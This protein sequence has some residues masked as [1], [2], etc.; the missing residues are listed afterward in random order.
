M[1]SL[2][3]IFWDPAFL[4]Q[5]EIKNSCQKKKKLKLGSKRRTGVI[6]IPLWSSFPPKENPMRKISRTNLLKDK[7]FKRK[8]YWRKQSTLLYY[9][10][11]I[12]SKKIKLEG[13]QKTGSSLTISIGL[14]TA[15]YSQVLSHYCLTRELLPAVFPPWAGSLLFNQPGELRLLCVPHIDAKLSADTR[16]T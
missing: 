15:A 14:W 5:E 8:R 3:K 13:K 2:N 7:S 12:N 11:Q 10:K 4:L 9:N 16:S 1:E 6:V